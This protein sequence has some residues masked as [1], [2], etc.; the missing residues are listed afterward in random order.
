LIRAV[1]SDFGGVLTSPLIESFL[2]Y[3][4]ESGVRFEDLGMAMARAAEKSGEH[5]LFELEKGRITEAEFLAAIEA[6]L[7]GDVK[8]ESLRDTYFA[9]L[10]PN[11]PMIGYMRELRGR[12][13]RMALLTN[14]VREWEPHW[15]E[16]LPD[17]DQIFEVVV[18]SAFVGM[19]KPDPAIYHLTLERLGDGLAPE[20]CVFVDDTDVN[21]DAAAALGMRAVRFRDADQARADLERVLGGSE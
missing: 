13:L 10:R 1:I 9:H 17:I 19:R 5:P 16:K 3:Q 20:A 7:D 21:C 2:A 4:D 18:D 12:G 14:N 8:L 6:E 15:R 11:E